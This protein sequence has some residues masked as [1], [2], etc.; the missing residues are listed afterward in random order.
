MPQLQ[1]DTGKPV[2]FFCLSIVFVW[3]LSMSSLDLGYNITI[4]YL[5]FVICYLSFVVYMYGYDA[6]PRFNYY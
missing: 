5:L 1:G 4:I 6:Y 2:R 3:P